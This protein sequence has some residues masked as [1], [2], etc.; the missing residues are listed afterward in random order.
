[1]LNWA[2]QPRYWS[3]RQ[4]YATGDVL[5]QMVKNGWRVTSLQEAPGHGHAVMYI[6][7]MVRD[8]EVMCL[9]VLDG[10]AVR[11]IPIGA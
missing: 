6:T 7:T 5:M 1:M 4:G 2:L 11:E 9:L 3:P 10:P 8:D